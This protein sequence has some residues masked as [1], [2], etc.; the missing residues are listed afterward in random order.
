[1]PL[2]QRGGRVAKRSRPKVL[3]V[4]LT[5]QGGAPP[6]QQRALGD[7]AGM[8]RPLPQGL[9]VALP[10]PADAAGVMAAKGISSTESTSICAGPAQY[11]PPGRTLG[12]RHSR[13][14]TVMSPAST[15]SRRSRL[16]STS[17]CYACG[18]ARQRPQAGLPCL[19]S[20]AA[21]PRFI[22]TCQAGAG[23]GAPSRSQ[24]RHRPPSG[25]SARSCQDPVKLVRM[26]GL[27]RSDTSLLVRTDFTSD[28]SW[29]QVSNEAQ[30]ENEDGF[31]AYLEP[32]ND[33]TFDHAN[34][35]TVKA[36]VPVNDNGASVLFIADGA[37]L[38]S[39]DHPILVV[40][41]G[42]SGK[43]PFRCIPPELWG[44][45][46]NLNISNMDWEEFASAVDEGGVFRGFGD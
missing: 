37:T 46:N 24:T 28:N 2:G 35:E 27:P 8:G 33:P 4:P 21:R 7:R 19:P 10:G 25:M 15:A 1:M 13:K 39:P 6:V 32:V 43:S 14:D 22:H 29:Q 26:P 9:A 30:R 41:L 5:R 38:T 17:R 3:T 20:P 45:E 44:V 42:S 11:R 34:W 16:N 12:R 23:T 40:D 31:R 18:P 36:A